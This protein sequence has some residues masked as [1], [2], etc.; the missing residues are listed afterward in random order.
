MESS[1]DFEHDGEEER[2]RRAARAKQLEA[3][4]ARNRQLDLGLTAVSEAPRMHGYSCGDATRWSRG[5]GA[6]IRRSRILAGVGML[7]VPRV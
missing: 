7:V 1:S 6:T 3:R 2:E 4:A 5:Q